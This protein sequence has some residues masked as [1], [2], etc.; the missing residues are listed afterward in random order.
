M[1]EPYELSCELRGHDEDVSGDHAEP[2]RTQPTF[3]LVA[4][5]VFEIHSNKFLQARY[6]DAVSIAEG[7]LSLRIAEWIVPLKDVLCAIVH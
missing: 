7:G 6:L 4:I 2:C 1:W 3:C 5:E